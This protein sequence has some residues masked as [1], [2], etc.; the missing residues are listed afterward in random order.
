[1]RASTKR[2]LLA[3]DSFSISFSI[4]FSEQKFSILYAVF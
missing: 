3:V 4:K 2:A 1:V